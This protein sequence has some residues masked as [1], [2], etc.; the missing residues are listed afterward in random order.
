MTVIGTRP[1]AVLFDM[2][3]LL[4]DTE[5]L[6]RNVMI[7]AMADVGCAMTTAD[8]AALIGRTE[9][10]SGAWMRARFCGLDYDAVRAEVGRRITADWGQFR[11]VKQGAAD[12]L[13]QLR[14]AHIPCA[15]VTSTAAAQARSHLAH[16]GLADHFVTFVGGDDVERGKPH[17]EP[18]LAAAAWLGV[19][20]ENC[21]AL[22]DSHNGVMSAHAAGCPVIMVPDLLPATPDMLARVLA[23]A[24]DLATVAAWLAAAADLPRHSGWRK[25]APC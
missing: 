2:D 21:L 12:L 22:E 10:D 11:P 9:Q 16:A 25:A 13:R 1:A 8:Y 24:P 18:Y 7:A 19:A 20:P 17:P 6:I 3:G 14:S 5:R 15:L 23:V 4:L